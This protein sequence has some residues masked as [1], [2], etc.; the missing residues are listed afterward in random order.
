M[1]PSTKSGLRRLLSVVLCVC[2][3]IPGSCRSVTIAPDDASWTVTGSGGAARAT[4]RADSVEVQVPLE[5]RHDATMVSG[6]ILNS[7]AGYVRVA[8]E[9]PFA[10]ALPGRLGTASG[11]RADLG[12]HWTAEI[13]PGRPVDVPPGT[14]AE[15]GSVD[16]ELRPDRPWSSYEAPPVDSTITWE[17][18]VAATTG[19]AICPVLFRVTKSSPGIVN[20]GNTAAV[21][22]IA[23]LVGLIFWAGYLY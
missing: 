13:V 15:P 11:D 2:A 16:F 23:A 21:V 12:G 1:S 7:G 4:W 20:E 19:D 9:A 6:S 3:A 8:F 22:T 5:L 18:T 14:P 10:V 17:I